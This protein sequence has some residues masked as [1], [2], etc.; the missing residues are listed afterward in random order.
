[1]VRR[2]IL[3][4]T[5]PRPSLPGVTP[6]P[7]NIIAVRAW[8]ATTLKETSLLMSLPYLTLVSSEALSRIIRVVSIS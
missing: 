2:I 3:L 5:Y 1:M 6:S 7:I 8:S 4:R